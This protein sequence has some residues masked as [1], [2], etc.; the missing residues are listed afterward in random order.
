MAK[1]RNPAKEAAILMQVQLG[2]QLLKFEFQAMQNDTG[3]AVM[4]LA[5]P[6][7]MSL[8]PKYLDAVLGPVKAT[9]VSRKK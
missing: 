7:V 1:K 3:V 4:N 8:I 6:D 5:I 2:M 9:K